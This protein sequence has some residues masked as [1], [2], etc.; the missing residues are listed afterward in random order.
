MPKRNAVLEDK[1]I[2]KSWKGKNVTFIPLTL[3]LGVKTKTF[4]ACFEVREV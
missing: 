2:V 3:G 1:K 4:F